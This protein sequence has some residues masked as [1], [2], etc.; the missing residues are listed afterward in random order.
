MQGFAR[1]EE[2]QPFITEE[3]K[4]ILK[5]CTSVEILCAWKRCLLAEK[6]IYRP[7]DEIYGMYL[8]FLEKTGKT[9][10]KKLVEDA[11]KRQVKR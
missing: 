1:T 3:I 9:D 6:E 5:I 10:L 7:D 8:E 4:H 2:M 11:E